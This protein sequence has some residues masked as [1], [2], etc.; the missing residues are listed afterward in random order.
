[1]G[2]TISYGDIQ[3]AVNKVLSTRRKM[4]LPAEKQIAQVAHVL[5]GLSAYHNLKCMRIPQDPTSA[6]NPV[7]MYTEVIVTVWYHWMVFGW[8]N[9]KKGPPFERWR[10]RLGKWSNHFLSLIWVQCEAPKRDVSWF[11]FAPVTIGINT[12]NHSYWTYKP[13]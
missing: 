8:P 10:P 4:P 7:D 13:T 12:I 5:W 9:K 1:M 6:R 11:R 2:R 3:C